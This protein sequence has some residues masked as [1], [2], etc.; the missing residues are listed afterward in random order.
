[1]LIDRGADIHTH[2]G[3]DGHTVLHLAVLHQDGQMTKLL[4]DRQADPNVRDNFKFTPLHVALLRIKTPYQ[5]PISRYYGLGSEVIYNGKSN[6][7]LS[8]K[9]IQILVDNG[10][11]VNTTGDE[12]TRLSTEYLNGLEYQIAG[13]MFGTPLN[14]ISNDPNSSKAMRILIKAGAK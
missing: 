3:K 2:Y 13:W 9:S 4:L 5:P 6:F 7:N 14:I 10:A 11:Q 1:L 12:K 8:L